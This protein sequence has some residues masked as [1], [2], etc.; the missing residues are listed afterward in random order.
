M[1]T[2]PF[3]DQTA[4]YDTPPELRH[5]YHLP[6]TCWTRKRT[7]KPME[8]RRV[9]GMVLHK[10]SGLYAFPDDPFNPQLI[11]EKILVPY[12]LSYHL[13]IYRDGVA[14]KR[15]PGLLQAFHAGLS[16]FE[17]EE[18]CNGFMI[19]VA[20]VSKGKTVNGVSAF[21]PGQIE[22]VVDV[23]A[24]YINEHDFDQSRITSH[25]QIRNGWNGHH[26]ERPGDSRQGDP[27][28]FPWVEFRDRLR[29]RLK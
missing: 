28:E 22:K 29:D 10:I 3:L 25:Q 12:R 23:A 17:G 13:Q 27:G 19:G 16:R 21:E 26:P 9:S 7:G 24:W 14:S 6:R 11:D 1:T 4:R 2:K 15:V 18:Y 5:M 8:M 20:L